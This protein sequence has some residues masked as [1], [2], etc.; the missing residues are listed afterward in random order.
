MVN[1]TNIPTLY[2]EVYIT[3]SHH[4]VDVLYTHI[5]FVCKV[6]YDN[7]EKTFIDLSIRL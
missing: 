2:Y 3:H 1:V 5:R 6:E 7:K 4:D